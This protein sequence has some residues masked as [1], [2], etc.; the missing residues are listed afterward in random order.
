MDDTNAPTLD[1][2]VLRMHYLNCKQLIHKRQMIL[3]ASCSVEGMNFLLFKVVFPKMV[4]HD[5]W[6]TSQA[7]TC[8][9][10][11]W[12]GKESTNVIPHL[13]YCWGWEEHFA[14]VL[15]F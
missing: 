5:S 1:D 8:P 3:S 6:C 12:G 14:L 15:H 11:W 13:C 4:G 2:L 10:K 9:F 7:S